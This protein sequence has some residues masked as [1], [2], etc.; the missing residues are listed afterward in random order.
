MYYQ[1][2]TIAVEEEL[3]QDGEFG[4]EEREELEAFKAVFVR[5]FEKSD[6]EHSDDKTPAP[7]TKPIKKKETGKLPAYQEWKV[8][9]NDLRLFPKHVETYLDR[10]RNSLTE[11]RLVSTT[12]TYKARR[13]D[14]QVWDIYHQITSEY[15]QLKQKTFKRPL[16]LRSRKWL[17]ATWLSWKVLLARQKQLQNLLKKAPAALEFYNHMCILRE[18]QRIERILVEE[19]ARQITAAR[20]RVEKA[21]ERIEELHQRGEQVTVGSRI[22]K[23]ESARSYWDQQLQEL[24]NAERSGARSLDDILTNFRHLQEMINEAPVLARGVRSIEEKFAHLIASHDMLVSLGKSVI[25]QEEIARATVMMQNDV[26]NLW[27]TGQFDELDRTLQ[28]LETFIGYYDSKV[29]SELSILERKRPGLTRALAYSTETVKNGLPQLV[30]LARSMVTA[31]DSRDRFMKGHSEKVTQYALKT[32]KTMGWHEADLESLELASLLH[33]VGKLS[34]PEAILTKAGPL[35]PH[36]WTII[37]MHP[38]YSAQIVQ[39]IKA[40]SSIIPWVYHHQERWDGGGYPERLSKRE[41][42]MG[43]SVIALAEAF[44]AMT[45]DMPSRQAMTLGEALERV[46]KERGKQFHPEVADA[47][48]E[49]MSS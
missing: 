30:A 7:Q 38:Y 49:A 41:I 22:L 48:V 1:D 21:I 26:A 28:S 3:L 35:T 13:V 2:L 5:E 10:I 12:L 47:F 18:Q 34:I 39:P 17:R 29:N 36:E 42:P 4:A 19:N 31:V 20:Q 27:A 33:D 14:E 23:M 15:P 46:K 43:A 11:Y 45:S 9:Q 40:L 8:Y 25:P 6:P 37:Q 44:S 32:A 16:F 24:L